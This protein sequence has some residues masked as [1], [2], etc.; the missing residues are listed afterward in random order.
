MAITFDGFSLSDDNFITER[1]VVKGFANRAL[2][3]AKINRREG[4]KLIGTEF[5]SKEIEVDG[6]VIAD[7]ASELQTLLD[8]LK[9]ALQTEEGNLVV[10]NRTYR[11]TVSSLAIADEHYNL[12]KAPYSITFV[13]SDP[14]ATTDQVS[15]TLQVSSGRATVS[16][17]IT[18]SGTFFAR[19]AVVYIPPAAQG[20][21]LIKSMRLYHT[22]TG[23]TTLVSGFNNNSQGGLRYQDQL[24]FNLEQFSAYEGNSLLDTTGSYPKWQPGV[25]NFTMSPSGVAFPGGQ[26]RV[27]YQPRYI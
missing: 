18:I 13:C 3:T 11:A 4:I 27:V 19:P 14:F 9:K 7:S 10:D 24:T 15:V 6:N 21:T 25:N 12:S 20:D 17:Q 22:N 5:T 2:N 16:G 8:N 1:V 23:Q 26:V